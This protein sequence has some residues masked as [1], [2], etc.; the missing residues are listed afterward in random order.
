LELK[1]GIRL[2]ILKQ[3][4]GTRH[5]LKMSAESGLDLVGA[6]AIFFAG[7]V[8]AYLSFKLRGDIAKVTIALTAFIVMH[9]IY[10]IV[11]MQGMESIADSLFEPASVLALIAFGA[12]YIGVSHKKRKEAPAK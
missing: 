4:E 1:V 2:H 12:T 11:R 3:V 9:G 5:W 10:H 6:I 8:P 7:V